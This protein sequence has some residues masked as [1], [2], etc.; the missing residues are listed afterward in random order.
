MVG[1]ACNWG[2]R[3]AKNVLIP[4]AATTRSIR[5]NALKIGY[6]SALSQ[7]VVTSFVMLNVYT[8]TTALEPRRRADFG[9]IQVTE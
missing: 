3:V 7:R 2:T 1:S 5:K 8:S 9:R 4:A 6:A